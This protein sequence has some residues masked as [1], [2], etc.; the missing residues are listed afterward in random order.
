MAGQRGTVGNTRTGNQVSAS[1][2]V[3]YNPNTGKSTNFASING[4]NSSAVRVGDNVYAGNDGK[5]YQKTDSG[6]EQKTGNGSNRPPQAKPP[7]QGTRPSPTQPPVTRPPQTPPGSTPRPATA[8]TNTGNGNSQYQN[9]DRQSAARGQGEQR[10]NNYRSSSQSMARSS[11]GGG[12]FQR[13]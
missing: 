2:G 10:T 5:V 13:R 1:Q 6:W 9:L 11:G 8:S 7:A 12:G 3:A 4:K